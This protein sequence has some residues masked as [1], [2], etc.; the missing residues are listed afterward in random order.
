MRSTSSGVGGQGCARLRALESIVDAMERHK[1]LPEGSAADN[2]NGTLRLLTGA[3]RFLGQPRRLGFLE[4]GSGMGDGS[5]GCLAS[6][7]RADAVPQ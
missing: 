6:G 1:R 3:G 2:A 4:T 5:D 7:C